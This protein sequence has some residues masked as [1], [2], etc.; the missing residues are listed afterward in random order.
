M[1]FGEIIKKS[2]IKKKQFVLWILQSLRSFRMTRVRRI[3]KAPSTGAF[4]L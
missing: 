4:K 2:N 1:I 3:K